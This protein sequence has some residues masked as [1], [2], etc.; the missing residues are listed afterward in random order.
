MAAFA[1]ELPLAAGA[2]AD[3]TL[4]ANN[5]CR[6]YGHGD[7]VVSGHR[8]EASLDASTPAGNRHEHPD[9]LLTAKTPVK[10]DLRTPRSLTTTERNGAQLMNMDHLTPIHPGEVLLED[11]LC[12]LSMSQYRLA[13]AIGVHPRRINE[14]VHGTRGITADTALRLAR[15]FGTTPQFWMNMQ[16]Q[17]E[18][19]SEEDRLGESLSRI[20]PMPRRVG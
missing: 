14:I 3:T 15:F 1:R 16:D 9:V 19:D 2:L 13:K 12:P 4:A 18:L 17:Y 5:A 6:H 10:A 11:F 20:E 8:H 7:Q